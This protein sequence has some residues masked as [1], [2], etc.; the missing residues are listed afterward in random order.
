MKRRGLPRPQLHEVDAPRLGRRRAQRSGQLLLLR[1]RRRRHRLEGVGH[2]VADAARRPAAERARD[3][4]RARRLRA[5]RRPMRRRR[6][7]LGAIEERGAQLRRLRAERQRRA[8]AAAVH[9]AAGGDHRHA[10][11]LHDLRHQRHG[12]DERVLEAAEEA[13]AMAARLGALDADGVDAER[14]ER[15]GLGEAGGGADGDDLAHA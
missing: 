6:A 9:D 8:H 4:R 3:H 5:Q 14:L 1:E 13:A 10:H 11:A 15:L 7:R 12:A 2:A